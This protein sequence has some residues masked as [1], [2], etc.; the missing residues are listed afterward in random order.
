MRDATAARG[1]G[2]GTGPGPALPGL[3]RDS[4]GPRR[5]LEREW[6][7]LRRSPLLAAGGVGVYESLFDAPTRRALLQEALHGPRRFD[8]LPQEPDAEQVRGGRPARQLVSVQGGA[9]LSALY[10]DARLGAFIGAQAGMPVRPCGEQ[11][12]FS[13]YTGDGAHLGL[14]RDVPGCDIALIA[15]LHDNQPDSDG[16]SIELWPADSTT[17]LDELRRGGGAASV[18]L[19]LAPGQTLLLH[20]GLVPHRIRAT[21]AGRL[22]IVALMCFEALSP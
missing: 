13:I 18:V 6:L 10:G 14:H 21:R 8:A 3:P 2:L 16:G 15:C 4:W 22:R 7:R 1:P 11:A 19:A 5:V 17:P 9:V 20:G 12:T